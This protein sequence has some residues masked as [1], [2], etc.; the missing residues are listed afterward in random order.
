M[1]LA[2]AGPFSC[3]R[4]WTI[5]EKRGEEKR[6]GEEEKKGKEKVSTSIKERNR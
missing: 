5:K 2:E 4:P 3:D 1:C 6:K